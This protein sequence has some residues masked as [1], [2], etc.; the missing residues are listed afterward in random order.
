MMRRL[1]PVL[2]LAAVAAA[3]CGGGKTNTASG[4]AS[5]GAPGSPRSLPPGA[6]P[7]TTPKIEESTENKLPA[8][9]PKD[10][11]LPK[12]YK[13]VYS[14]STVGGTV[15]FFDSDQSSS[16]IKAFFANELP[17]TGWRLSACQ[18]TNMSPQPITVMLASKDDRLA[19]IAIGYIQQ[20]AQQAKFKGKYAFY[21]AVTKSQS[22]QPTPSAS[23]ATCASP[24]P[25]P[26]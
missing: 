20:T 22:A 5:P 7:T 19:S 16:D 26:Q 1:L 3:G 11:P 18:E 15:V 25:K 14:A 17:K 4:S 8:T 6:S 13:I 9:W 2:F 10:F 21:A 24:T 12:S 23:P